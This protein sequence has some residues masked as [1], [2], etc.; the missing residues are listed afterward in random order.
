MVC[1]S[2]EVEELSALCDRV[3]VLAD[4]RLTDEVAGAAATPDRLNQ[5]VHR[6]AA[7]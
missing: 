5:L 1:V 3:L 6:G 4:G 7:A 2:S